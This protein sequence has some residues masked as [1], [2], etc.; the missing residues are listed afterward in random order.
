MSFRFQRVFYVKFRE[1]NEGN[2]YHGDFSKGWLPLSYDDLSEYF[3]TNSRFLKQKT[4]TRVFICFILSFSTASSSNQTH[5]E[6]VMI[7]LKIGIVGLMVLYLGVAIWMGG[8]W[9][10]GSTSHAQPII[11]QPWWFSLPLLPLFYQQI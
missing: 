11:L 4:Y 10:S 9:M 5:L 1:N 2:G 6:A 8:V 3:E 7:L